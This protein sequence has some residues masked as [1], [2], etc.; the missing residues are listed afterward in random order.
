MIENAER[1]QKMA[2]ALGRAVLDCWGELPHDIQ[3]RLFEG[4]AGLEG[5]GFRATLAVYL[6][7]HHPR[8][9]D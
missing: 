8:T 5:D 1:T 3:Q 4:A 6:H 9:A 7:E 2:Q